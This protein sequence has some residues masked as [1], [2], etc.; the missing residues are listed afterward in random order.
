VARA[1][2]AFAALVVGVTSCASGALAST[3]EPT[4]GGRARIT[5]L[6]VSVLP[7]L[8]ARLAGAPI[9]SGEAAA[10]LGR[11]DDADAAL[12]ALA[13]EAVDL[14]ARQDALQADL[15]ELSAKEREAA[16]KLAVAVGRK[17]RL[18]AA[19]YVNDPALARGY[20]M[21]DAS[22]PIDLARRGELADRVGDTL[23]EVAAE[24]DRQRALASDAAERVADQLAD[25]RARL[26]NAKAPAEAAGE[27]LVAARR[28][29]AATL[30]GATVAGIDVP[31]VALDA[32][33]RAERLVARFAPAC[34]IEWWMLAGIG[35]TE[36]D[37][38]RYRDATADAAGNVTP[39]I[40]G[41][42]LDGKGVA[43]IG[44]TDGGGLDGDGLWDRAVG[45]MQFIPSTW[46]RWASDATLD[47]KKDPNNLYDA[48]FA[49]A[50]YLCR[51]AGGRIDSDFALA[52]AYLGYNHS[53]AYVATVADRA[54]EYRDDAASYLDTSG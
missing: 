48:A 19:A 13:E 44:D 49:A 34:G 30:P 17:R 39:W 11:L 29:V 7:G 10:A 33:L 14:G 6:A 4:R 38:G 21:L 46:Q 43:A 37:H 42:P 31:L 27:E 35:R 3:D 22:G 18:A 53:A 45:P 15:D 16:E 25:V 1:V 28:H 23:G 50:R 8:D 2:A 20:A 47:G 52:R 26:E 32:Y 41:V 54:H 24:A 12:R 40:L 5:E 51:A 36:S 9:E